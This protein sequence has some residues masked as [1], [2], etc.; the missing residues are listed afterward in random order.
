[1]PGREISPQLRRR[2]ISDIKAPFSNSGKPH[3]FRISYHVQA[4]FAKK[5]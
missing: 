3:G 5:G 4:L 2:R 1:M